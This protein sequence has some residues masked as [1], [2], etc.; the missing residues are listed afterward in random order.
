MVDIKEGDF[1]SVRPFD[2]IY[3]I[4][5]GFAKSNVEMNEK[6]PNFKK[7]LL[8]YWA[9][10]IKRKGLSDADSYEDYWNKYWVENRSDPQV[11]EY[12]DAMVWSWVSRLK[13]HPR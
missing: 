5:L 9:P 11:W 3:P 6:S 1:I 2:T 7:V 10:S 12:V 8:Q 13:I 4:W